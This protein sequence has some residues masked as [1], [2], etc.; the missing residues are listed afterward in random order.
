MVRIEVVWQPEKTQWQG[1]S[2]VGKFSSIR[3]YDKD[4]RARCDYG[5]EEEEIESRDGQLVELSVYGELVDGAEGDRREDPQ[6]CLGQFG[7]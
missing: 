4:L 3:R 6:G 5:N 1:D 2:E 7:E